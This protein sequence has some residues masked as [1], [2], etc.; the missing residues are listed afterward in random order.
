MIALKLNSLDK[1]CDLD[2]DAMYH[3]E[4]QYHFTQVC[5]FSSGGEGSLK[6][7]F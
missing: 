7:K 3:I 4:N 6:R 2:F 5:F 1:G